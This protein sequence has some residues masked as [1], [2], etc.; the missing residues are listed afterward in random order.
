ML[1]R[2]SRFNS[3]ILCEVILPVQSIFH[4]RYTCAVVGRCVSSCGSCSRAVYEMPFHNQNRQMV[5]LHRVVSG[6]ASWRLRAKI[7]FHIQNRYMAF[8]RSAV[9]SAAVDEREEGTTGCTVRTQTYLYES[10]SVSCLNNNFQSS[11]K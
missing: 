2:L 3:V 11:K 8:L 10:D 7:L 6:V 5:C 4:S 9:A 1:H